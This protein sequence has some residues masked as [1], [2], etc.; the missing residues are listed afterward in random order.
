MGLLDRFRKTEHTH[1]VRDE[2]GNVVRVV[3]DGRDVT[4]EMGW[5]SVEQLER[6]YYARHPEMKPKSTV[7]KLVS[8]AR[9]VDKRI[10]SRMQPVS[11]RPSRMGRRYSVR[12]N[13]NP[14][15]SL[16]DTGLQ[17]PKTVRRSKTKYIIRGGVA[18]PV[19]KRKRTRSSTSRKRVNSFGFDPIDNWGFL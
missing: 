16:F 13:Y 1:F 9:V 7:E 2:A 12:N 19:V 3:R 15:G 14:F 10:V 6:E 8:F 18:Y 4:D 11:V 5:K 17:K